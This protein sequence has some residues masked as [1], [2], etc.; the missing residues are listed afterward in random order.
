MTPSQVTRSPSAT[1]AVRHG[2]CRNDKSERR[3]FGDEVM[4]AAEIEEHD[5]GC[6]PKRHDELHGVRHGHPCQGMQGEARCHFVSPGHD[7]FAIV[8]LHPV[9]EENAPAKSVV[10][11]GVFLVTVKTEPRRR[12]SACSSGVSCR[13]LP[14]PRAGGVDRWC[15]ERKRLRGRDECWA[16]CRGREKT[17][18]GW[19]S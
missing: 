7:V 15:H 16:R 19:A 8:D 1:M 10:A 2:R 6:D 5:E 3:L 13:W 12:R 11:T 17:A 9:N 4:R 18:R 14:A